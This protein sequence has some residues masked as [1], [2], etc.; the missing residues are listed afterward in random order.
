M[1][2]TPLRPAQ[3]TPTADEKMGIAWWN[4]MSIPERSAALD[5]ADSKLGHDP[6][7]ADAWATW[8]S[9]GSPYG[10]KPTYPLASQIG[11]PRPELFTK[12]PRDRQQPF[13]VRQAAGLRGLDE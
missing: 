6:S 12:S 10:S 4:Q 13:R 1:S 2:H 11:C 8:K 5:A 7:A 3:R 9:S